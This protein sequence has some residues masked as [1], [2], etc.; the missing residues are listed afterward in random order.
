MRPDAIVVGSGPAGIHAARAL[1]DAGKTV[2]ILDGGNPAPAILET[3][4]GN[5]ED[6]RLR[7]ANQW[8]FFLGEN[9]SG[10]PVEGIEGGHEGGMTSGNRSY[11][12]R[13]VGEQLP[14]DLVDAFV[15]Q[16]LATG[17]LGA[18]WGGACAFFDDATI[19]AMGIATAGFDEA[20]SNVVR[21][22]G[23]SGPGGHPDIQP[24]LA[25]DH[26]AARA[27]SKYAASRGKFEAL[28]IRLGQPCNAVLSRPMGNRSANELDDMDYYTDAG[29]SIY[30]PQWTL[31]ELV[32]RGCDYQPGWVA[33]RFEEAAGSVRIH[34]RS[35]AG[36]AART[37]EA[38]TLVL[39]AGAIGSA[40]IAAT[41]MDL[42]DVPLPLV[43][44]PH[45]YVACID[46]ASLGRS[47]PKK[48]LSICQLVM[49]DTTTVAHGL[50]SGAA[51][52]YGYRSL[53][54]FRLLAAVPLP[55]PQAMRLLAALT[56]ALVLADVRFP[57]FRSDGHSLAL[58]RDGTVTI[59]GNAKEWGAHR[60]SLSRL[61]RGLRMA[62]LLPLRTMRGP[63]GSSSHYAGTI[64]VSDDP[65]D[66]LRCDADGLLHG[67]E[68]V[69]V[70][71]ASMFRCLSPLPHTL[72]LMANAYR[73]GS[74]IGER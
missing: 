10:I 60:E 4:T 63:P 56:P 35:I 74:T 61:K 20:L 52:V 40:R 22:I 66:P 30:R 12:T 17:G 71:D 31:E 70:A 59:R 5:F 51:Q 37:W 41:S 72:T 2:T 24:P 32:A 3:P 29:R 19:A 6:V 11:V 47:G 45:G 7:D 1:M 42:V 13:D 21:S 55:T 16:S 39:A 53:L 48:R 26:H 49:T 62:G 34:A 54:L 15:V 68:R 36:G 14:T 46:P 69:F 57:A 9:L 23:V 58:R 8:K 67:H 64:P 33:T 25:P 44:K 50:P 27:L 65:N 43:A 73:V 18:A 38:P 28:G